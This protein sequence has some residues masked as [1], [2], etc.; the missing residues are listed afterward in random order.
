MAKSPAPNAGCLGSI[1]GQET[2]SHMLQLRK[3]LHATT[4]IK[5]RLYMLQLRTGTAKYIIFLILKKKGHSQQ[6]PWKQHCQ[7]PQG[8]GE[9][10]PD[11]THIS[12]HFL[13]CS[14][15]L[16]LPTLRGGVN[17]HWADE[18][19]KTQGSEVC[20]WGHSWEENHLEPICLLPYRER[21]RGPGGKVPILPMRK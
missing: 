2:R 10:K 18:E 19:T 9:M 13:P 11:S 14:P 16:P 4:K 15:Y 6:A 20:A 12:V 21:I 3:H 1:P 7:I 17:A 5:K 8:V